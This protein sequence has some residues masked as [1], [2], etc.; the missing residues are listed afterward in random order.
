M[1]PQGVRALKNILTGAGISA[2][3]D[4]LACQPMGSFTGFNRISGASLAGRVF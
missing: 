2:D 4:A 1:S 3:V